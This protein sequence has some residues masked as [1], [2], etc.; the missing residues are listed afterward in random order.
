[1]SMIAR[2]GV[3]ATEITPRLLVSRVNRDESSRHNYV[4]FMKLPRKFIF[5]FTFAIN[6]YANRFH[7]KYRNYAIICDFL[8]TDLKNDS[9]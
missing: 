1:M 2:H 9:K 3:A 8:G 4:N 6:L 5:C 7:M